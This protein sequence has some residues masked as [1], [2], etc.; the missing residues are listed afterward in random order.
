MCSWL[1]LLIMEY[2]EKIP[3]IIL[4]SAQWIS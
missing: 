1:D 4:Q 2:V 3:L